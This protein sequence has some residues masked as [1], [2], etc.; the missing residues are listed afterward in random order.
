MRS[1]EQWGKIFVPAVVC[2]ISGRVETGLQTDTAPRCL[3]EEHRQVGERAGG[4]RKIVMCRYTGHE[5]V[6]P[7]ILNLEKILLPNRIS[8]HPC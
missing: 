4:W 1:S 6:T 8:I 3:R 5:G 7:V 2:E